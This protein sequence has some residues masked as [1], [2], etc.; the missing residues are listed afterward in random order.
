M[1]RDDQ[2]WMWSEAL[3]MMTR[4]E[5]MHRQFFQPRATREA[6][7]EPP[8]DM[9]EL[10]HEVLILV[11]LPGV[12]PDQVEIAIE[13]A[14]LVFSGRR[15]LPAA[16]RTAVIHRLE[17]PQG[18]FERRVPLPAGSYVAVERSAANG[19]LLLSLRKAG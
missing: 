13:G 2:A 1:R 12:D 18:R 5:Q 3:A 6:S 7:W 4:A 19:C 8:V 14:T 17:L 10:E 16:L 9:L 15:T 11:A